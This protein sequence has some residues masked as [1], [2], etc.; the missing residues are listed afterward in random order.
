MTFLIQEQ[1]AFIESLDLFS[2]GNTVETYQQLIQQVRDV[3]Q[4]HDQE[5]LLEVIVNNP[6]K[7]KAHKDSDESVLVF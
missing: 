7:T 3:L 4:D 2:R 5:H 6:L 1:Q